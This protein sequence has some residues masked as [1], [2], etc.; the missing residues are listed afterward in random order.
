MVCQNCNIESENVH[1]HQVMTQYSWNGKGIDPNE[2]IILCEKCWTEY[3]DYWKE[4]WNDYYGGL[5]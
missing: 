2:D 1:S 4:K 5:L 3:C